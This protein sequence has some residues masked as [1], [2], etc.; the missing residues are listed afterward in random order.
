VRR[1]I[2]GFRATRARRDTYFKRLWRLSGGNPRQ[3]MYYWLACAASHSQREGRI[4]VGPLPE[5]SVDLLPPVTISQR[6]ILALI[7]Q[8]GS[9][10]GAEL[11]DALAA[12]G[13]GVDGDI[14]VLWANGYLMPSPE[15]RSHMVLR[16]TMAH[17]L[18]MELRSANMI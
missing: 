9:L 6:L 4:V 13:A 5:T 3:A 8:H 18:L 16:S 1:P 14:K 17:P 15:A 12:P 11:Q 7:A 10:T 2:A